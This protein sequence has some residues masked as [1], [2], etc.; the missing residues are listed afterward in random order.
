M[1]D[2]STTAGVGTL[3]RHVLEILEGEV[4]DLYR[5]LGFPEYR[6]RFSPFVK[7][8]VASGPMSI[9]AL[10]TAIEVTHSAAGQT[11]AQ[12]EKSGLVTLRSGADARQRIVQLTPKA[13][14][15]MPTI[16]AEW[17][18]TERA[19][20]NLDAELA[21]PIVELL[22]QTLE[23]LDERSL[24]ERILETGLLPSVAIERRIEE[25]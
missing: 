22:R 23:R 14:A 13:H 1:R 12:M 5:D 21:V 20:A 24:K 9:R 19:M 2:L 4:A 15:L 6:P 10:A 7:M 8:L 11:V 3:L 17:S 25:A 16:E 18:A